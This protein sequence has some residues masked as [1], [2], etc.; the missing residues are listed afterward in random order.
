M[1]DLRDQAA[2]TGEKE[3]LDRALVL[4]LAEFRKLG[5]SHVD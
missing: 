5:G 4:G 2:D 3:V 1:E